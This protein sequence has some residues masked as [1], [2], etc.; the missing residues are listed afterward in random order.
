MLS[1]APLAHSGDVQRP[2]SG[3]LSPAFLAGDAGVR[4]STQGFPAG[5]VVKN[6]LAS[7]EDAGL[8]PGLGSSTGEEVAAHPSAPAWRT[9]R[10]EEPGGLQPTRS[11]SRRRLRRLG[12][13]EAST[14]GAGRRAT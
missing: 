2:C 6:L 10:T 1:A 5:S 8:V 4:T 9:P 11:Q 13:H 3:G 7:A 14:E 12:M